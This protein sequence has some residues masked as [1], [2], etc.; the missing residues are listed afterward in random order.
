MNLKLNENKVFVCSSVHICTDTRI[1][2]K[3]VISLI[4]SGY[5]VDFYAV[6]NGEGIQNKLINTHLLPKKGRWY[7]PFLWNNLYREALKSDA[8]F[9]H[10]H[11]P[12]LLFVANKLRKKKPNA[13][14]VYDMHEH[15]PSQILTKDWVPKIIRKPLSY[16]IKRKEK[17]LL[18][19]CDAIVFAEKSYKANYSEYIGEKEEILN[20]PIWQPR[21]VAKKE[22]KFTFIYVGDIVVERNIYGM[23]NLIHE[24]KNRGYNDVQ[25][26]LIG[27]ISSKLKIQLN[28]HIMKLNISEEVKFYGR[29]SYDEIWHHYRTA[30]VGLCL[31]HPQPNF[32]HSLAT[33]MFEYMAVGLPSMISNFPEWNEFI[34]STGGGISVNP[35]NVPQIADV[36]EELINN[37]ILREKLSKSGRESYE[38][39]YN[40]SSEEKKL[41]ALYKRLLRKKANR[42]IFMQNE[43]I[44]DFFK[45]CKDHIV[46]IILIP[47]IVI[48][49][50]YIVNKMILPP[51]YEATTQLVI[52]MQKVTDDKY[53]FDN[54]R[55]SMQLVDTFSSIAQSEKVMEEV[56]NKLQIKNNANKIAVVTDDKSLIVNINV[57]G[58][59]KTKL[60]M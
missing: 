15:F 34:K 33:K 39:K 22:E 43:T 53:Y 7:R 29:L 16:W 49:M 51:K 1:Y 30:H 60:S 28:K 21:Y 40:W 32:L 46:V 24:L 55:S 25:L 13:I 38:K 35:L 6:D 31:L 11:D 17:K 19:L 37:P 4:N 9:Y 27:P 58:R 41:N 18:G 20:F 3:Q 47:I 36:A 12:E 26:K 14:F 23:V 50:V 52:S 10:F 5:Q 44:N 56:K 45:T 48:S 59:E 57:I 2:Y 54:L 42:G 8:L